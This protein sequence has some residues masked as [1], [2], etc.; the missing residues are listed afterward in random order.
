MSIGALK[1]GHRAR[2]EFHLRRHPRAKLI[3]RSV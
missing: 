2:S 1:A 3:P